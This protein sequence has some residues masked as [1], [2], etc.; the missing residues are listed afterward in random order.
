M[1]ELS[2][3]MAGKPKISRIG[4][5]ISRQL[6]QR[7]ERSSW[8][9]A[10][11]VSSRQPDQLLPRQG[12]GLPVPPKNSRVWLIAPRSYSSRSGFTDGLYDDHLFVDRQRS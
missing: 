11:R 3:R 4:S 2:V 9:L 12:D 1:N 8:V 5:I 6:P 7:K 10:L